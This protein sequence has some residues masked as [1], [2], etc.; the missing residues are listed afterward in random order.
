MLLEDTT[1][2]TYAVI[3]SVT[4]GTA[5]ISQPLPAAL[6]TTVGY[7]NASEGTMS[8]GDAF[9]VWSWPLS[10]VKTWTPTFAGDASSGAGGVGWVQFV[11]VADSS[12]AGTSVITIGSTTIFSAC[13]FDS[14]V[15]LNGWLDA[16]L[17]GADIEGTGEAFTSS[18]V[19]FVYGGIARGGLGSSGALAIYGGDLVVHGGSTFYASTVVFGHLSGSDG[20]YSDTGAL[21]VEESATLRLTGILWGSS[22]LTTAPNGWVRSNSLPFTT[23]LLTSGTLSLEGPGGTSTTGSYY[24][25]GTWTDGTTI[26]SANLV[27]HSGLQSPVTHTGY[28]QD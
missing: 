10:N 6:L 1:A 22:A 16:T 21:T 25:S 28:S 24:S 12:G 8:T 5:T 13:R 18:G 19:S 26:T 7:T 3:D 9:T 2:Q 23:T 4:T 11:D 17:L 20:V 27:T 14:A 15:S